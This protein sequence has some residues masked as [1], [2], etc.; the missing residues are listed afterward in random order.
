MTNSYTNK[1]REKKRIKFARKRRMG[2]S[3]AVS[4]AAAG[5]SP[6]TFYAWNKDDSWGKDGGWSKD[7]TWSRG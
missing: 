3:I 4:S 2:Y 5:I 6:S 7:K 1:E